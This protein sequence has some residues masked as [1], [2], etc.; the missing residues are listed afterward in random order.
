MT[1]PPQQSVYGDD[2]RSEVG[3]MIP[4]GAHNVLDVGCGRGGFGR[5]LRTVLGTDAVILGVD[6]VEDNVASA[7]V[8]HGYDDVLHGYFPEV[9][10]RGLRQFD[11]ITF[12]DVL[13]HML[14]PW[15]TLAHAHSMLTPGGRVVAAIPSIQVY[16][17]IR[18]LLKGRWDYTDMGTLDRT[19]VRFFTRSTMV[20]MFEGAGF[21]VEECRGVNSQKASLRP[22]RG[23]LNRRSLVD[24]KWLPLMLPD[25]QWLQFVVVGRRG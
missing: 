12:L 18:S 16:T 24:M 10:P 7:R 3:P 6:A 19:H 5:T 11:L 23:V 21:V 13:E 9:L 22:I 17:L 2:S 4:T 14:D 1:Q 15:S 20:E 25:S 8:G